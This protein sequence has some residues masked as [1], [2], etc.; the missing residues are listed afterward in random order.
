ML[1]AINQA[2]CLVNLVMDEPQ[3]NDHF[4]CPGCQGQVRLKQG[5]I[6]RPHFAHI[7]LKDCHYAYEN[8]SAQHLELKSALYRWLKHE[9]AVEIEA[10][11]PELGQIA[12]LLVEEKLALEVQCSSLSI[13]RLLE[14]TKAY[15]DQGIEVL[16]LLGKDLWIKDKLTALQ[17]QFLRFSQNMGFHLWELDLDKQVLR[18]RYLIHE[19]WHGQVQCLTKIFPFEKGR[20]LSILRQPYLPQPLLSFQGR[21]DQQLGRYIAQQLYY[22]APKWMELQRQ[23]YER[24]ENLLT[25]S[26]DD[27]YPQVRLPQS[28]IGFAQIRD[29]LESYYQDFSTYYKKQQNKRVQQLYPPA[30]YRQETQSNLGRKALL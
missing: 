16:W 24:G 29:N 11:L 20:L 22:Q 9:V 23:A 8:E 25:Q 1:T 19:D 10:V 15:Q 12:D 4:Y 13:Q 18:L 6:L 21:M 27:F 7:I 14:R 30:F 26:P 5:T 17:K 2:G 3:K 28:A